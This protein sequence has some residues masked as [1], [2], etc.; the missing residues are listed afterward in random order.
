VYA[1]RTGGDLD[2]AFTAMVQDQIGGVMVLPDPFFITRR[3][4]LFDLA[5]RHMIPA[6]YPL[7]VRQGIDESSCG[8]ID[9]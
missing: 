9:D 6:N 5:A 8:L 4:H 1:A 2:V 7:R 3:E